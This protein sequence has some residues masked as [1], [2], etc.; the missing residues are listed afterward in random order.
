MLVGRGLRFGADAW[1][2]ARYG[3]EAQAYLKDNL[4]WASLV[5]VALVLGLT[6]AYRAWSR[7]WVK[8]RPSPAPGN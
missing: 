8:H 7:R 4:G 2:G 1:L 3:P 5:A 6:L